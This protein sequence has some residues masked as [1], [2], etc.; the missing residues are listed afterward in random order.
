MS[1]IKGPWKAIESFGRVFINTEDDR[2]TVA[3]AHGETITEKMAN[4]H[5][6]AASPELLEALQDL[7]ET[8]KSCLGGSDELHYEDFKDEIK[9]AEQA[10][11]KAT[12]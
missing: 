5:L 7:T 11:K 1:Y 4:A 3:D 2:L 6:I 12:L 8:F 9:K 10:I